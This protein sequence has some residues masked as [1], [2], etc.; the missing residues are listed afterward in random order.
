MMSKCSLRDGDV[1][2]V[3]IFCLTMPLLAC[4]SYDA[5]SDNIGQMPQTLNIRCCSDLGVLG[6]ADSSALKDQRVSHA[7]L[8]S[9]PQST[10]TNSTTRNSDTELCVVGD[11]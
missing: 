9:Q 5:Q 3:P 7:A 1:P 10:T 2:N 8:I 11:R 6:N 4:I